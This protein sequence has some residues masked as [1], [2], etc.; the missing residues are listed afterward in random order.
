MFTYS[1]FDDRGMMIEEVT[2]DTSKIV[3]QIQTRLLSEAI[4]LRFKYDYDDERELE[5]ILSKLGNFVGQVL[6]DGCMKQYRDLTLLDSISFE[7]KDGRELIKA[8]S[9]PKFFKFF[10]NKWPS[11]Y[12]L[13][14]NVISGKDDKECKRLENHT[15][16]LM[17]IKKNKYQKSKDVI[18]EYLKY[19]LVSIYGI[20]VRRFWIPEMR[21]VKG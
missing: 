7:T 15:W 18:F 21:V 14:D 20:D 9:D 11:F 4:N 19:W 6:V 13:I 10:E 1:V 3:E 16:S 2:C 8:V 5:V 12:R 17:Y